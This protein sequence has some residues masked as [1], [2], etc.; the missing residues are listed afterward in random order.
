MDF[1]NGM[2]VGLATKYLVIT[3]TEE[4]FL[5]PVALAGIA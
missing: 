2:V 1:T 3:A 4:P 5:A